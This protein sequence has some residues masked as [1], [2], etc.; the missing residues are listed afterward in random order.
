MC[1]V[2]CA[3]DELAELQSDALLLLLLVGALVRA[4]GQAFGLIAGGSYSRPERP[5][6]PRER[7]H[8]FYRDFAGAIEALEARAQEA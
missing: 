7:F 1:A 3:T 2:P 5:G 8:E 4:L 6:P